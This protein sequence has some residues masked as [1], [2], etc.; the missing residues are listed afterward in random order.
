VIKLLELIEAFGDESFGEE[1][2]EKGRTA[3]GN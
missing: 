1:F 2:F 3:S